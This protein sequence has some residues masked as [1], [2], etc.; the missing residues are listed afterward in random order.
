MIVNEIREYGLGS[1]NV[2]FSEIERAMWAV[3]ARSSPWKRPYRTQGGREHVGSAESV[4]RN[5][6]CAKNGHDWPDKFS[7]ELGQDSASDTSQT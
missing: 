5:W 6:A 1:L 2:C 4:C 3:P 7:T